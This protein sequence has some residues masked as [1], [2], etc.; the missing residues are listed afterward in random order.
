VRPLEFD[1]TAALRAG[2]ASELT[3]AAQSY[4]VDGSHP[5]PD[6]CGGDLYVTAALVFY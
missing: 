3:Y 5:S 6:G 4:W 1:V 2:E